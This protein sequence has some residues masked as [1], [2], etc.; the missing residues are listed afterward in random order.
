MTLMGLMIEMEMSLD[1]DLVVEKG[2]SLDYD[3]VVETV[4]L[5]WMA[6]SLE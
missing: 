2:T 5:M 4:I 1:Y 6:T 3:L